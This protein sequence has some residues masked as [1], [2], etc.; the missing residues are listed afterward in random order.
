MKLGGLK[1]KV[2]FFI[3]TFFAVLGALDGC[4]GNKL[5]YGKRFQEGINVAGPLILA[6]LGILSITPLISK[7]SKPFVER[8]YFLTGVDP[9][10]YINS[11][12]ATDMGGYFLARDLAMNKDLVEFSGIILDS[13]LGTVVIFTMPVAFG[14]IDNLSK[15][16]FSK[17]ILS[18]VATIPLGCFVAGIMMGLDVRLIIY[19]LIP[20]AIFSGVICV[21]LWFFPERTCKLF[22]IFGKAMTVVITLGLILTIVETMFG[23]SIIQGL[24]PIDESM[25]IV[26][27]V[28]LTLSGAY[29]LLYFIE[30]YFKETLKKMGSLLEVDES[31]TAGFMASLVSSIPMFGIFNKMDGN[32]KI[33]NSAFSVAGSYV[34]GGQLGF[35][36][37]VSP[38]N[39]LPFIIAKLVAGFSAIYLAKTMFINRKEKSKG[40]I[41]N[42][43]LKIN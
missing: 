28:T 42:K 13:M 22:D 3:L 25:K 15:E 34:F 16:N 14:I 24:N 33:I 6:M 35:V 8:L 41:L 11:I 36:A 10:I 18:G 31:G 43:N 21:G 17:G 9:S 4:F 5:G 20:V 40:F 23:Y 27:R 19:N 7:I 1:L 29:P 30:K 39:I 12:L 32:S 37:G 26:T 2:I 38:D